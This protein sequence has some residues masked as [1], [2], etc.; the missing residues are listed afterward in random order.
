MSRAAVELRGG[1]MGRTFSAG[2]GSLC[3]LRAMAQG[4]SRRTAL[5]RCTGWTLPG[6]RWQGPSGP[7]QERQHES[8]EAAVLPAGG[9]SR[10]IPRRALLAAPV[11]A[12]PA[13][14]APTL[15]APTLA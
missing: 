13:L 12:A 8:I 15:I 5:L 4:W 10:M 3:T 1:V 6:T 11:L 14:M 2:C 9:P 7:Q